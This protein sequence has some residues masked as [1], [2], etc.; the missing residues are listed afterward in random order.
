VP[1]GYWMHE[2][3]ADLAALVDHV[4]PDAPLPIIG[5]SLGGNVASLLASLAPARVSHL[6]SLDGFGPLTCNVPVDFHKVMTGML[7]APHRQRAHK[8]YPGTEAMAGRLQRGN[9][10]LT[11]AQA[12]FLA[13]AS[14]R[15][16]EDGGREWLFDSS[17]QMSL[18][19]LRS[20]A[21]WGAFWQ[22]ITAPVLWVGSTDARPYSPFAVPGEL[23]RRAA[24]VPGL[25]HGLLPGT[26]HNLHHDRPEDVARLIEGFLAGRID[27]PADATWRS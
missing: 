17:H 8:R 1:Q 7:E 6:I 11:P 18:P 27:F 3:V 10:N 13:D 15:A 12:R 22:R 5:H 19:S 2:F 24:M 16:T 9:P 26:T 25:V 4:S 14:S 21:E 20:I 23:D